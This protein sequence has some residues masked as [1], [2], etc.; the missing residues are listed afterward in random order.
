MNEV[1][2][3]KMDEVARLKASMSLTSISQ[4]MHECDPNSDPRPH[5][6]IEFSGPKIATILY[7]Q[8][9]GIMEWDAQHERMGYVAFGWNPSGE[10]HDGELEIVD[11]RVL[12]EEDSELFSEMIKQFVGLMGKSNATYREVAGDDVDIPRIV[13]E[14]MNVWS[15][16]SEIKDEII[17]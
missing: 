14:I 13:Q 6:V 10:F 11:M 9:V 17:H 7:E 4:R 3:Y 15:T 8:F 1:R 2:E 5:L 16:V 12:G